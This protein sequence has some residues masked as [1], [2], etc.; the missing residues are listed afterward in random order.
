M[1]A[2]SARATTCCQRC[3]VPRPSPARAPGLAA[4][5]PAGRHA[6]Q[7]AVEG[8][9]TLW[10][11]TAQSAWLRAPPAAH[12]RPSAMSAWAMGVA[13]ALADGIMNMYCRWYARSRALPVAH[14]PDVH[15]ATCAGWGARRCAAPKQQRPAGLVPAA[16]PH[17]SSGTLLDVVDAA[18]KQRP[19]WA[20]CPR[21]AAGASLL[22]VALAA[23]PLCWPAT[24]D[25]FR[26][27]RLFCAVLS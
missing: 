5:G 7:L 19:F 11:P 10:S 25:V 21:R 26:V 8:G 27:E 17:P 9:G 20:W 4:P 18:P 14:R 22:L 3:R 24:R 1:R 15:S 13:G 2:S 6:G 23:L 16:A 12:S